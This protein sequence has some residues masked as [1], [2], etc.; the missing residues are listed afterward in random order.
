M[1]DPTAKAS[2]VN[3]AKQCNS[4]KLLWKGHEPGYGGTERA[5]SNYHA[6]LNPNNSRYQGPK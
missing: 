5:D 1:S 6:N 2:L 3:H 4:N